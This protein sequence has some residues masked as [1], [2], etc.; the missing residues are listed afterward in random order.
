MCI[1]DRSAT[2]VQFAR[3]GDPNGAGLPE[4]P[5]YQADKRKTMVLDE[6]TRIEEDWEKDE[7]LFWRSVDVFP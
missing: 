5:R 6:I 7:L 2:V 3:H 1:R 4:W